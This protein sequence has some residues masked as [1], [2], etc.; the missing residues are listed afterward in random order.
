M[1]SEC[2][3]QGRVLYS[4]CED[5]V[6]KS[7]D[8]IYDLRILDFELMMMNT[9]EIHLGNKS[10]VINSVTI[11]N[12]GSMPSPD[13]NEMHVQKA[14]NCLVESFQVVALQKGIQP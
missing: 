1:T 10:G 11:Q 3:K 4:V 14:E 9:G 12:L 2:G 5:G 13:F 8:S 6:K 7:Y